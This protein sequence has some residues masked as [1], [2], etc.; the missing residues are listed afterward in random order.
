MRTRELVAEVM[1]QL[2]EWLRRGREAEA[3]PGWCVERDSSTPR[4]GA[5]SDN[6]IYSSVTL[7]ASDEDPFLLA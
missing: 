6:P 3:A 5:P 2:M 4:S 7:V 1:R